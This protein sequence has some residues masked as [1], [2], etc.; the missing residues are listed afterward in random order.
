MAIATQCLQKS[1]FS[2]EILDAGLLVIEV[3]VGTRG[4]VY[5]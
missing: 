5:S 4:S 1:K 2:Y 3:T